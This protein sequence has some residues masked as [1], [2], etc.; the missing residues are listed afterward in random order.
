MTHE[1][2]SLIAATIGEGMVPSWAGPVTS[3]TSFRSLLK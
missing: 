2:E 1:F 3:C